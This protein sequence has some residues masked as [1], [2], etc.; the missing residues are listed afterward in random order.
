MLVGLLV[1]GAAQADGAPPKS[2]ALREAIQKAIGSAQCRADADCASLPLGERPCGGPEE[3]LPYAPSQ[4]H[5]QRL[6]GLAAQYKVERRK[7]QA[8]RVSTCVMR[9]DPGARCSEGRCVSKEG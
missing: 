5:A 4:V 8:G 3:Y 6:R 2:A 1:W 9:V 7:E